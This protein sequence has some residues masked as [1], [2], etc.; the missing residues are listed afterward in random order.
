MALASLLHLYCMA[1]A[2]SI[3]HLLHV[4]CMST[5]GRSRQAAG[6]VQV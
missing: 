1:L 4:Y 2:W 5:A 3:A 6:L